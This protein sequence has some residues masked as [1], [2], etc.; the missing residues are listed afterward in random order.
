MVNYVS[1]WST[2]IID[3]NFTDTYNFSPF[4]SI[5]WLGGAGVRDAHYYYYDGNNN[6]FI[7]FLTRTARLRSFSEN[8]VFEMSILVLVVA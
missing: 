8:D 5:N 7:F 4:N 3:V 6:D 1:V 2:K